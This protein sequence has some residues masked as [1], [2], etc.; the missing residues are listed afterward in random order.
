MS[1]ADISG[2]RFL[3]RY[4]GLFMHLILFLLKVDFPVLLGFIAGIIKPYTIF[5]AHYRG[6][7]C[8]AYGTFYFTDKN[9]FL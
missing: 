2:A 4:S 6:H 1:A 9:R 8:S 3:F 7:T 5:R